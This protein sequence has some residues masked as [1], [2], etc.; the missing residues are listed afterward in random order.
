[1]Q[2][3]AIGAFLGLAVGDALGATLEFSQRDSHKHHTEMTG[4]GPF[5]LAPGVWTDDTSMAVAMADSL[6][7]KKYFDATD[8]MNR[9]MQWRI[10]GMY[11]PTH[12]CFDIGTTTAQAMDRFAADGHPYAGV[13]DASQAGNGALMRLAPV[14]LASARD[15]KLARALAGASSALTHGAPESIDA[16]KFF[17][18]LL[19][20]A[21]GGRSKR[22]VIGVRPWQGE[23]KV[24]ALAQGGWRDKTRDQVRS[25]GYVIDT[26]EAALWSVH[27]TNSFE[28]ALVKAVNLGDDADTVGAVTGQLAGA[29]YGASSIPQRWLKKLAWRGHIT[30]MADQLYALN[31]SKRPGVKMQPAFTI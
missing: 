13:P 31:L 6:L 22:D 8:I 17:A 5:N 20:E 30:E 7:I 19:C 25:S 14:A 15:P 3:K 29:I 21:M 2:D 27:T 18:T 4:G 1:M 12:S 16:C 24:I 11:S 28:E 26:L 10:H 23:R 9:F